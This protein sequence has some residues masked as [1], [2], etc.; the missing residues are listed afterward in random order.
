M[1]RTICIYH[2]N[3]ADGFGAAWAV[4]AALGPDVEFVPGIYGQE[5]PDVTDARVLM[6]D[7]S[8]KRPVIE[9]MAEQARQILI[10]D[11]HKSAEQDLAPFIYTGGDALVR[12]A[13]WKQGGGPKVVA[14]FDMERSGAIMAWD[15]FHPGRRAPTLLRYI[16]DRDL[17]RFNMCSSR[18]IAAWLFSHPYEFALW[19]DFIDR[20]DED[21]FQRSVVAQ[22][23]AITR[24]HEKDI[25]ELVGIGQSRMVIG[26]HSVPVANLPYTMSSDA[27]HLMCEGEPFA[28]CY[29]DRGDKRVFSL[30][31]SDDGVDVSEVAVLYGGG[32]H[33]NA[34]GF[35]AEPGWSG[36]PA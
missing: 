22:G 3:C 5:P 29:W 15:F 4:R 1:T 26:N 30:R 25:A 23:Q 28:A 24:K 13:V 19:Q 6:V 9:A 31:S 2:G 34:A 18:D 27:G 20:F 32:G 35:E 8:Y 21:D 14:L 11:H 17:W 33:R 7:F 12:E 10:L 16:E 36:E